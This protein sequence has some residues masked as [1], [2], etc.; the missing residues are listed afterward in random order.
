MVAG[1]DFSRSNNCAESLITSTSFVTSSNFVLMT[2][3]K[4]EHSIVPHFYTD[5]T[6]DENFWKNQ[7]IKDFGEEELERHPGQK[8]VD[9]YKENYA[10]RVA[11]F[12]TLPYSELLVPF[13]FGK[14]KFELAFFSKNFDSYLE[15]LSLSEF[16]YVFIESVRFGFLPL[17]QPMMKHKHF[18]SLDLDELGDALVLSANHEKISI[19]ELLLQNSRIKELNAQYL[20][21]ALQNADDDISIPQVIGPL[22]QHPNFG[23]M[24][25]NGEYGLGHFFCLA[26]KGGAVTEMEQIINS[27]QFSDIAPNGEYSLGNA[28]LNAAGA[29][30]S[31]SF[32]LILNN[33]RVKEIDPNGCFG[34]GR[35]LVAAANFFV[36]EETELLMSK[37]QF[38]DIHP[39]GENGL[40]HAVIQSIGYEDSETLKLLM[41]HCNFTKIKLQDEYGLARAYEI[42]KRKNNT[43]AT[44]LLYSYF[45][46]NFSEKE[47]NS[48]LSS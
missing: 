12:K 30:E 45:K 19:M 18:N 43:E 3:D 44:E 33:P 9:I 32:E 42:A 17:I 7:L 40:G 47:L 20:V 31:S 4:V 21:Q 29:G 13:D 36:S 2:F 1:T 15:R 26:A 35:V 28:L 38:N 22:M 8:S 10:K 34:F 14:I 16:S 11:F 39:D 6:E 46:A 48:F 5:L 23:R 24:K 41:T 37:P 27:P 25:I